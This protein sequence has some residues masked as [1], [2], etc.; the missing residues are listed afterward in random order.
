MSGKIYIIGDSI[1][2][3]YIPCTIQGI[4]NEV[5]NPRFR[6]N[7]SGR[8]A[9]LGG[10][11]FITQSLDRLDLPTFD[12]A[13]SSWDIY[14]YTVQGH[15]EFTVEDCIQKNN[16]NQEETV[17]CLEHFRP[18]SDDLVV[19]WDDDKSDPELLVQFYEKARK[20]GSIIV[21]DSSSPDIYRRYPKV[22][23]YKISRAEALRASSKTPI[24]ATHIITDSGGAEVFFF[25]DG[26]TEKRYEHQGSVFNPVDPIGAGDVFLVRLIYGLWKNEELPEIIPEANR[27]ARA[28]I[29]Y[30]GCYFPKEKM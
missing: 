22:D 11:D 2:D 12:I 6:K 9:R 7:S 23:Y 15:T 30:P 29:G 3:K 8:I 17:F 26:W 27:L 1:W 18:T 16:P 13:T 20:V 4:D 28:S 25:S 10:I 14:R 24:C 5:G 21:V 19:F